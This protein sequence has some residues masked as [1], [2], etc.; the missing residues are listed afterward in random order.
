MMDILKVIVNPH[1][2]EVSQQEASKHEF[3]FDEFGFLHLK[4]Q[5][6][7]ELPTPQHPTKTVN[8]WDLNLTPTEE[9]ASLQLSSGPTAPSDPPA[10]DNTLP[11]SPPVEWTKKEPS[12]PAAL[13]ET[14]A[15][16]DKLF[17]DP[18]I[19]ASPGAVSSPC[20]SPTSPVDNMITTNSPVNLEHSNDKD[21]IVNP[22]G[23]V[24]AFELARE[25]NCKNHTK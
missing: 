20:L 10:S 13:P 15:H 18:V 24:E 19:R 21:L 5:A 17:T 9:Q 22:G 12:S 6:Q 1:Q 3:E 11:A 4:S 16:S 7:T 8:L 25:T 2:P 23:L 14:P